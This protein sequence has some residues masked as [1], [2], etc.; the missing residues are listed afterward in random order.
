M[1]RDS[2]IAALRENTDRVV[3][4]QFPDGENQT[5]SIILVDDEGVV[6]DLVDTNRATPTK[7]VALWT[8]FD[9][10]MAAY[11]REKRTNLHP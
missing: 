5:A 8:T 6:Y 4:L 11:Q 9:E 10:I 2:V 7:T 3:E 1:G